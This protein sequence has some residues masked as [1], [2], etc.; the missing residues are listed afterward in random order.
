MA[1]LRFEALKKVNERP[2]VHVEVPEKIVSQF[3][4]ENVFGMEQ[5]RGTLAPAVFNKVSQAI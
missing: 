5:M 2:R 3:Y 1:Y 4:G